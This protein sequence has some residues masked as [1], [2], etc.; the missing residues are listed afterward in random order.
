MKPSLLAA[1]L[2]TLVVSLHA[3]QPPP[4]RPA[5]DQSAFR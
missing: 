1:A 4:A 5:G 3:Q 2:A